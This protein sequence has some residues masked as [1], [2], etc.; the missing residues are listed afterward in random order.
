LMTFDREKESLHNHFVDG[1][2]VLRT[3]GGEEDPSR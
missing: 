1:I 3:F 2:F